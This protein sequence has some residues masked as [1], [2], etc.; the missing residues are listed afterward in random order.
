MKLIGYRR[1]IAPSARVLY[2]IKDSSLR[3]I[4]AEFGTLQAYFESMVTEDIEVLDTQEIYGE[5][6]GS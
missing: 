1:K 2:P 6:E 4:L 3:G 5:G